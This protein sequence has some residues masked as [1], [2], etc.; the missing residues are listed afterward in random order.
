MKLPV[1]EVCNSNLSASDEQ[2]KHLGELLRDGQTNQ[3][4]HTKACESGAYT[5]LQGLPMKGMICRLVQACHA[6]FYQHWLPLE[7]SNSCLS[8]LVQM[9]QSGHPAAE[10][11]Y[12]QYEHFCDLRKFNARI[13]NVDRV[14]TCNGQFRCHIVWAYTDD[15]KTPFA[16]FGIDICGWHKLSKGMLSRLQGCVGHYEMPIPRSPA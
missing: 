7:T 2:F 12:P 1:H 6:A 10:N 15:K 4:P 13:G 9:D 14:E 3:P 16:V 11:H 5:L 8:P